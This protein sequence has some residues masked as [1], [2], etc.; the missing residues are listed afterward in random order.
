MPGLALLRVDAGLRRAIPPQ[1]L[2]LAERVVVVRRLELEPG[3]WAPEDVVCDGGSS[4]ALLL[5]GLITLDIGL[6]GCASAHLLGPGDP[7]RP[8]DSVSDVLPTSARWTVSADG[9]TVA[10]LDDQFARAERRWP[11]LAVALRERFAEQAAASALR[12]AI[13]SLPRVEQ[14]V[15]A[16]FW[17]LAD[18]WGT[19]RPEGI[20]VHLRLTHEL[21]GRL[22]GAKRPTVSLALQQLATSGTLLRAEAG[23]WRLSHG[24]VAALEEDLEPGGRSTPPL[25][26]RLATPARRLSA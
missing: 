20:V 6:A 15:L 3:P 19:V 14:R 17:Q 13:A 21:I 8:W 16:L 26:L 23:G 24:S 18:R 1:E 12:T 11:G 22:V 4:I 7:L 10:I 2:A 25:S 9:A 5:D